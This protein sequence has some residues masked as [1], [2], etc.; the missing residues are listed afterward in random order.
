MC[1][2][3]DCV[4]AEG[5]VASYADA[6]GTTFFEAIEH[7]EQIEGMSTRT[8][9]PLSAFRDMMHELAAFAKDHD[10]KPSEVVAEVLAKSGILEELQRSEDPQDASRVDNLSQL[11]SVAAEFE[12]N[13]PDATLAGFLETTALVADSDQLPGENEDSGKVT[14][15]TL[16]TAK[17]LEYPY[18][19]LTGMEQ[20]TFPHQRAM[21]DTSELAEER[22][23]A[24]VGITR[25]KRRLYVT[26]AAVR[27]QWGQASDMMPSQFLD[28]IP[29][30]LIDWKRREAGANA[31]VPAGRMTTTSS[32]AGTMMTISDRCHSAVPRME[33]RIMVP[34]TVPARGGLVPHTDR[35]HMG[36]GARSTAARLRRLIIL[37][38]FHIPALVRRIGNRFLIRLVW[39]VW[40]RQVRREIGQGHHATCQAEK[41]ACG[42]NQILIRKPGR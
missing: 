31:C 36:Q 41:Q 30:E 13:T 21:E 15:M 42:F 6:H 7:M 4:R 39:F 25:A 24:Y 16:H 20:G 2:S 32:A 14:M 26:R 34:H 9:K 37:V 5:L 11:Q 29:D 12:Q 10:T 40:L 28:E 17:G 23:L 35:L 3:A 1:R 38:W 19:F 22:R 27:A 18:V 33:S 8:T